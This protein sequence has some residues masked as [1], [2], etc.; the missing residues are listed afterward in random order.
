MVKILIPQVWAMKPLVKN[1]TPHREKQ[2]PLH[3]Q[4]LWGAEPGR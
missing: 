2:G 3:P 1:G 4:V